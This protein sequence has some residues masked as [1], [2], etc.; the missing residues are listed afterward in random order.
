MGDSSVTEPDGRQQVVGN[1]I[2]ANF[3]AA[4]NQAVTALNVTTIAGVG[5]TVKAQM[6]KVQVTGT[7][8]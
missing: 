5:I 4:V 6:D 7:P 8:R 3:I 2:G 1:D